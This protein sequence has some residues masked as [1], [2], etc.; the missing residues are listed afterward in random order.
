MT[1][2]NNHGNEISIE[3][4]EKWDEEITNEEFDDWNPVGDVVSQLIYPDIVI[5][6]LLDEAD[7]QAD[8][9]IVRLAHKEVFDSIRSTFN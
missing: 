1:F 6:K 8:T 4:F 5:E 9:T 7:I 3:E 2:I